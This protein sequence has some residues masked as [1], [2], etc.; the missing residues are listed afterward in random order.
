MCVLWTYRI[1][2][3]ASEDGVPLSGMWF[4]VTVLRAIDLFEI[5]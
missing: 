2:E 3:E 5:T 1:D 4:I